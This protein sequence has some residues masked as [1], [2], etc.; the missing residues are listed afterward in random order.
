MNA[1]R[2]IQRVRAALRPLGHSRPDWQILCEMAR[3]LGGRG[4]AFTSPEDVW[5]EVRALCDGARG[6]TYARLEDRGLQWPCP[7]EQHP[8]TPILHVDAFGHGLRAPLQPVDY[9]PTPEVTTTEF[10]F[11]LVTGRSLYQFNA[12]TMTGRTRN[13]ELRP[14]DLL[15]M[16]P[17]DAV[18]LGVHEGETV[19][20][21]SRYGATTLP[22]R[23]TAMMAPGQLFATFQTPERMVNAVTSTVRD[24]RVGT[25]E[26]KITAVAVERIASDR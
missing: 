5:N 19:R 17:A 13:A 8:G 15:D 25:P 10:P 6:M 7:D 16:S 9:H 14:S 2:R 24:T 12:A 1:E 22:V 4:F 11:V 20:L 26:Y 21:R 18:R 23:V 3:A